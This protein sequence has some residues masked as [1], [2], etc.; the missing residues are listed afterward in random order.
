MFPLRDDNPTEIVP[1]FTLGL[2][3]A[4]IWVWVQVQGGGLSP[5]LLQG[6][7]CRFGVIPGDL[8]G[9]PA[10]ADLPPGGGCPPGGAGW[11]ALGSSMFLHGSWMHL[12]GNM[13]FLW[14]FGNNIEDSLGHLRFLLFYLVTGLAAAGAQVWADPG[15][16][17]PMVG[18]SGA[19][20]GVMGAYLVLYPRA[21][22]TT[23]LII[24]VLIQV[25]HLPA[26]LMLGYWFLIQ[27]VASLLQPPGS[28]GVAFWAHSGGFIAGLLLVKPMENRLLVDAKRRKVKLPRNR[29]P[30]RGWW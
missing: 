14:I 13:W 5:V 11:V 9:L 4:C 19:I 26:W 6:S 12:I 18:A 20:S 22:I 17:L 8:T 25:V 27:F 16:P 30:R 21:R 28:G 7:V 10:S 23:L 29:I 15:S 1:F 3:A 24:V 2:I